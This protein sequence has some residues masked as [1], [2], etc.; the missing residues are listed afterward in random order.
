MTKIKSKISLIAL[1]MLAIMLS[2]DV[3]A[4]MITVLPNDGGTSGNGRAPSVSWRRI[5]T[6]YLITATE[7]AAAGYVNGSVPGRIGWTYTAAPIAGSGPLVIYMENTSDVTNVK[8]ATWSTAIS[9]MTV[10]HNATTAFPASATP[11]ISLTGGS[12]FTYTGGGLY[13]AF[14]WGCYTGTIPVVTTLCNFTGLVGGLKGSQSTAACPGTPAATVATSNFRPETRLG[15]PTPNNDLEITNIYT[16]GNLPVGYVTNHVIS[17]RIVNGGLNT[18]PATTAN[19]DITGANTFSTSVAVPSLASG[20]SA[21]V[22][23]PAYTPTSLGS[24]S[25]QVSLPADDVLSNNTSTMAQTTSKDINSYRYLAPVTG[26][27]G[28]TGG[29]GDFVAKFTSANNFGDSD[30]INGFEVIFTSNTQPYNVVVYDD[31]GVGG[32]PGTILHVSPSQ[33]TVQDTVFISLPDVVVSGN[34]YVGIRQTNTV[35]VGFG[36]QTENPIRLGQFYFGAIGAPTTDFSTGGANFRLTATVQY[37]TPVPP[38]CGVYLLPLNAGTACQNGAT[39]SYGS[40]GGGPTGYRVYFGT[41]QALVQ[42]EDPGTLVQNSAATTYNTGTL[43]SG[44]TYYWRIVAYNAQG[45]ATGCAVLSRSFTAALQPCYC[46]GSSASAAF[47]HITNVQSG[48]FSN[49][50][51]GSLYSNYY[52]LGAINNVNIG[53][54]FNITVTQPITE[55]YDED[56][57][58]VYGDF[59]QDGDWNDVGELCGNADVTIANGNVTVVTC[60]VPVGATPGNTAFRIKLGDEVSA[61]A[62]NNDPCQVGFAFGEVEDYLVNVACGALATATNPA[63]EGASLSVNATYLGS[64]TPTNYSWTTTAANGFTAS[65][66]NP[67]VAA[68]ASA[69]N[70][71]GVYTV[72]ITDN[73]GCTSTADVTVAVNPAPQPQIGGGSPTEE[74]CEGLPLAFSSNNLAGGQTSTYSWSSTAANGF[75]SAQQNVSVTASASPAQDNGTYTVVITNQFL[76]TASASVAA[77]VNPNP[78]LVVQSTSPVGCSTLPICDG[79]MVVVASGGTTPYQQYDDGTNFNLDGNFNS[80]MC[81]GAGTASVTDD[82]GCVGTVPFNI[83]AISTGPPSASVVVPPIVNLPA[84]ACNGTLVNNINVPSVSGATKYNWDGPAG[85][86]FNG[87]GSTYTNTTP[88]ANITFG[89]LAGGASGYYIGV[90]AANACG[91]SVR[92]VQWVRG[93]LSVPTTSG[94]TVVCAGGSAIYS[95]TNAPITGAISYTWTGPAGT[96]FDGNP[97]PYTSASTSVTAVLPIGFTSGS[98]CVTANAA[99]ISSATKCISVSTAPSALGPMSGVFSVCPPASQTYTV[100]NPGVVGGTYNWTLPANAS[101]TSTSDNINV[102]FSSGFTG[103]NISVTYTNVCGVTSAART[104]SISIG[105]PSVPA[106]ITTTT[107]NGLCGQAA[108]FSCP[109]QAGATFNWTFPAGSTP[110]SITGGSNSVG[111]TMP[112]APFSTGQVCVTA[113]NGCGTSGPRCITVKGAPLTPGLI[114]SVPGT[115]CAPSSGIQFSADLSSLTGVYSLSWSVTPA[116]TATYVSG[117]ATNTYTVD[118][119]NAG[120]ASVILT[121]SNACGNASRSLSLNVAACSRISAS[122]IVTTVDSKFT[123][124]PNP[125]QSILNFE[126]NSLVSENLEVSMMDLSGRVVISETI[127]TTEGLNTGKLDVSHLAKGVYTFKANSSNTTSVV[128]I[129]VE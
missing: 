46:A 19:L 17:A 23:F 35:N 102:S 28:F 15:P 95:V 117:Q 120:P 84:F 105:T 32:V 24:S 50:T 87:A 22:S 9:T 75:T 62:M 74:V 79:S 111:S 8:S 98:I 119:D 12:P 57:I 76:C 7:L 42:A 90:Q 114:S 10:V 40:G 29:T 60:T 31:D 6:H 124:Y 14:D 3:M 108:S 107:T 53:S 2:V 52:N 104:K 63:C 26:G 78:T 44:T 43:I 112:G 129:V 86:D 125:A 4:Q 123:V 106:S 83:G 66:A 48:A 122:N 21:V 80:V 81:F 41:N 96:T 59:N 13:I 47:E 54:T 61:V 103:G 56:R 55:V 82:K 101:G 16:Q 72:V 121:A 58:Y 118:W 65:T 109:P 25:V 37:K 110:G 116:G 34:Y 127:S 92:K 126:F 33:N 99:C 39:L 49:P 64:G 51:A 67:T 97:T 93:T 11:N 5:R 69:A 70:D 71:D 89:A 113:T 128:R 85:T 30:T 18:M 1:A 77:T 20:A 100:S 115:W 73:N 36:Y 45:D 91:T 38:N 88:N 68:S 94:P 27:V